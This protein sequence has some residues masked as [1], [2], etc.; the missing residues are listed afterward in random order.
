M[1]ALKTDLKRALTSWGFIAGIC[2]LCI[3][4]FFGAFSEILPVYNGEM[5]LIDKGYFVTLALSGLNS[6]VVFMALPVLCVLAFA[7]AF[8]DDYKSRYLTLYLPRSGPN[9]YTR[10]KVLTT[11]LS[12]GLTLAI[13]VLVTVAVFAILFI[14]METPVPE[15]EETDAVDSYMMD[16]GME[17]ETMGNEGATVFIDVMTRALV[18]F[19]NG[20][21][22][23]LVG[24]FLASAT[25]SRYM[26][27]C[28]PFILCYVL[29]ILSERYL[30]DIYMINPRE[31]LNPG[32]ESFMWGS[33]GALI[34]LGELILI[35]GFLYAFSI[36]RKLKHA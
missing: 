33:W 19:A 17:Y 29:L 15:M 13:G 31:W 36:R 11:A 16:Y 27:Y 20:C 8:V 22:W 10:G 14:P 4:A 5:E 24:G 2:G 9:D 26:A 35:C 1:N 21:L 6:E 34:F 23:A 7:P 28:S 18:F 32:M 25:M 3:A 30:K 12:G